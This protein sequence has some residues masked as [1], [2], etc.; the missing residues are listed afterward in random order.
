MGLNRSTDILDIMQDGE[1]FIEDNQL[2]RLQEPEIDRA[3]I[4]I[5]ELLIELG[6]NIIRWHL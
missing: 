5:E 3:V 6:I 2:R 4:I 1:Q